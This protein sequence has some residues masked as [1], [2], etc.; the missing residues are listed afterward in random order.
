M[1]YKKKY[2]KYKKKYLEK[3]NI[4][5]SIKSN[6]L[7]GG[8]AHDYEGTFVRNGRILLSQSEVDELFVDE[9]NLNTRLV[10]LYNKN[11]IIPINKDGKYLLQL[12]LFRPEYKRQVLLKETGEFINKREERFEQYLVYKY[13]K[14]T[15]Y[16]LEIGGRYGLVSITINLLLDKDH[17]SKHVVIE[18]DSNVNDV[19]VRNRNT[20]GTEFIICNKAISTIPLIFIAN[21]LGSYTKPQLPAPELVSSELDSSEL[22]SP[23]KIDTIS[24]DDFF[25][26]YPFFNVLVVDCEGCLGQFLEECIQYLQAVELIIFEKDNEGKC[27]YRHIYEI[28]ISNHFKQ[29]D[30]IIPGHNPSSTDM[31]FQQ[32]WIKLRDVSDG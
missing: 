29:A 23:I 5:K 7:I 15:D 12:P 9:S 18:P 28:L 30:K 20:F 24:P 8:S 19:L 31:G 32:V 11:K 17:K 25:H 1:D 21:E 14:P 22:G 2:L 13:I 3:K 27:D 16:V 26:I 6:Y 4:F 10:M